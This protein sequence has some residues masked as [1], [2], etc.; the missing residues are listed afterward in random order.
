MKLH[1]IVITAIIQTAALMGCF[2]DETAEP[3]EFSGYE[4]NLQVESQPSG[5]RHWNWGIKPDSATWR[6][7]NAIKSFAWL[8]ANHPVWIIHRRSGIDRYDLSI[9]PRRFRQVHNVEFDSI[10]LYFHPKTGL[11]SW[12]GVIKVKSDQSDRIRELYSAILNSMTVTHSKP[13]TLPA[14]TFPESAV[15]RT[16]GV[17]WRSSE[18]TLSLILYEFETGNLEIRYT[19]LR[20]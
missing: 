18:V 1:V 16:S 5:F 15:R 13:H 10:W 14:M 4:I 19:A 11:F 12:D 7:S 8:Q 6:D 3:R 9:L 2:K 20:R 17:L